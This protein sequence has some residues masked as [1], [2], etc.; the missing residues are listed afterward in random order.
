MSDSFVIL[1]AQLV[2]I[3][4]HLKK[5][6]RDIVARIPD[7]RFDGLAVID[8]EGWRPTWKRNWDSKKIYQTRSINLLRNQHPEWP[9]EQL[10]EWARKSFEDSARIMM[11]ETLK[12][13]KHL[14]P[15]AKW[16][17]YGFPDCYG[18]KDTNYQ[19]SSERTIANPSF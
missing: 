14:R 3:N 11:L 9:M 13:G 18:R 16:G 17:F 19:C 10:V 15:H 4:A 7:P 5:S 2:D 12:L 1:N 6:T 8:W